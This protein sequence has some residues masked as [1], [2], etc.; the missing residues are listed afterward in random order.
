MIANLA[1]FIGIATLSL[2]E[3]TALFCITTFDHDVF[4]AAVAG[5]GWHAPVGSGDHGLGGSIVDPEAR[6]GM[7]Q[8][9]GIRPLIAIG[10]C[11]GPK[12]STRVMGA[13]EKASTMSFYIQ[14]T[15]IVVSALAGLAI[16]DGRF[17]DS[18][19]PTVDFLLR[20]WVVPSA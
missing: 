2:A 10:L 12:I 11:H 5:I 4:S 16:G 3:A 18:A 1:F 7:F 8:L 20:A 14:L 13:T 9:V 6:A 19:D 17:G 15:L